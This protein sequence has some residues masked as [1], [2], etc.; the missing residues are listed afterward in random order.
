MIKVYLLKIIQEITPRY[1]IFTYFYN[2]LGIIGAIDGS[3]VP[4]KGPTQ[5]KISYYNRKG[6][7]SV[8]LQ[9]VADHNS[10]FINCYAGEVGSLHDARV[11]R[12]SDIGR[13]FENLNVT[14]ESHLLGDAAYPLKE[15][16]LTPYK[17]NGFLTDIQKNFNKIHSK[18]RVVIEQAFGLLKG[19]FRRLKYLDM[20]R[21][22]LIPLII[23]SACILHNLCQAEKEIPVDVNLATEI[24]EERVMAP[25]NEDLNLEAE[26][27]GRDVIVKRNQIAN[28]LYFRR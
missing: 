3:H 27:I 4:I 17:D 15:N 23:I 25:P 28:L 24:E 6:F 26:I 14:Y 22:D 18:S 1:C 13:N 7:T 9:A 5:N 8:V 2:F 20:T 16:L 11:F 12:K 21:P 19:R 10:K